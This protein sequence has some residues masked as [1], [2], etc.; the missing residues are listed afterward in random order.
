MM[1]KGCNWVIML[2]FFPLPHCLL[3]G[4]FKTK[5]LKT[6]HRSLFLSVKSLATSVAQCLVN[7]V[8]LRCLT[9]LGHLAARIR[10]WL[11]CPFKFWPSE[12][13]GCWGV[14][15]MSQWEESMLK[16]GQACLMNEVRELVF[17]AFGC[18][19]FLWRGICWLLLLG[20]CRTLSWSGWVACFIRIILCRLFELLVDCAVTF[21][22]C[23]LTRQ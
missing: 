11:T 9:D 2:Y 1:M 12:G 21:L 17:G 5:V 7:G 15:E 10:G 23:F 13:C 3:F 8:T 18:C 20:V 16:L 22:F 4:P 6:K 14:K 19:L